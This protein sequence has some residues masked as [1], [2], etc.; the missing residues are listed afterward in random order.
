MQ[1]AVVLFVSKIVLFIASAAASELPLP[2]SVR[3]NDDSG[4]IPRRPPPPPWTPA[5]QFRVRNRQSAS[6]CTQP[7]S[8]RQS[9]ARGGVGALKALRIGG[10]RKPIKPRQPAEARCHGDF[11]NTQARNAGDTHSAAPVEDRQRSWILRFYNQ[12]ANSH[13]VSKFGV[14]ATDRQVEF[15]YD[16]ANSRTFIRVIVIHE[17]HCLL[18]VIDKIRHD[19]S[20]MWSVGF[21]PISASILTDGRFLT[22]PGLVGTYDWTVTPSNVLKDFDNRARPNDSEPLHI[23]KKVFWKHADGSGSKAFGMISSIGRY[24]NGEALITIERNAPSGER[25]MG[26]FIAHGETST[27]EPTWMLNSVTEHENGSIFVQTNE[28]FNGQ[29]SCEGPFVMT[30]CFGIDLA[31]MRAMRQK[32]RFF[33]DMLTFN[34]NYDVLSA[35]KA[36]EITSEERN[37]IILSTKAMSREQHSFSRE[38]GVTKESVIGTLGLKNVQHCASFIQELIR[39]A[40]GD[41]GINFSY[42]HHTHSSTQ[43]AFYNPLGWLPDGMMLGNLQLERQISIEIAAEDVENSF[44]NVVPPGAS[45]ASVSGASA[46]VV[47]NPDGQVVRVRETA[48]AKN[49]VSDN[50]GMRVYAFEIV[51]R[52]NGRILFRSQEVHDKNQI[53]RSLNTVVGSVEASSNLYVKAYLVPLAEQEKYMPMNI[54]RNPFPSGRHD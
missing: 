12:H 34:P 13:D 53:V 18:Q 15:E 42:E 45:D 6:T 7:P 16:A 2:W 24:E 35:T 52:S 26:T 54:I 37:S 21:L 14:S 28:A 33:T 32:R 44:N 8:S 19:R 23:G 31:D 41:S 22:S 47:D 5:H 39:R 17:G 49:A 30:F 10:P 29:S 9:V 27:G 43:R 20:R 46:P 40:L 4:L 1:F 48:L 38:L 25:V 11:T 50:T 3:K 51:D 36:I